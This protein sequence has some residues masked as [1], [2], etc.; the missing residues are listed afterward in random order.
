[1]DKGIMM[2]LVKILFSKTNLFKNIK[3]CSV[4]EKR[5]KDFDFLNDYFFKKWQENE[6]IHSIFDLETFNFINY[7]CPYCKSNDRDRLFAIFFKKVLK[8]QLNKKKINLLDFAPNPALTKMFKKFKNLNYRSVDLCSKH[9]D[10]IADITD[11]NI[12][13][14]NTFKVFLCSHVL[15]HVLDDRKAI[16]ELYRV[17]SPGGFGIVMVPIHLSF[18]KDYEKVGINS[19]N[20]RW[21]H[22]GQNDHVREYSKKGFISKLKE[23]GFVVEEIKESYF[24]SSVFNKHGINSRST[25]YKVIKL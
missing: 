1:M 19:E 18:S 14:D 15:E 6:Y 13:K 21:K 25:L 22:F 9:A 4:C 23:P 16:S 20:E 8:N 11:L 3:K 17:L 12:Y 7:S 24:G 2:K 5:V 10:D